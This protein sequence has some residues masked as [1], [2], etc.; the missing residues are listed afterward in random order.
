MILFVSTLALADEGP[1]PGY[2]ES[3][4]PSVCGSHEAQSC[5]AY[6]GGR[7]DCENLEKS[8]YV[9]ACQTRG[10]SAWTEILCKGGAG[11]STPVSSAPV[12]PAPPVKS[13]PPPESARCD[14]AAGASGLGAL[15]L[16][17]AALVRRR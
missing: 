5:S 8:G 13:D 16:L 14:T 12:I 11:S 9:K 3:C 2:V 6:F 15:L 7:E 4:T 17:V 1:P 10:A